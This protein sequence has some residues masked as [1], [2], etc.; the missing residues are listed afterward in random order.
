MNMGSMVELAPQFAVAILIVVCAGWLAREMRKKSASETSPKSDPPNKREVVV[1]RDLFQ[2]DDELKTRLRS[3]QE[4][5]DGLT[6]EQSEMRAIAEKNT[7]KLDK[8]QAFHESIS[9]KVDVV[10][11]LLRKNGG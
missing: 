9:S 5:L 6:R 4:Q 8:H 7:I 3:Q 1:K 2:L 11:T 10:L